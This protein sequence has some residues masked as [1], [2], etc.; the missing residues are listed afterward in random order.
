MRD[1]KRAVES[2][3][4]VARTVELGKSGT[5]TARTTAGV[6]NAYVKKGKV[7]GTVSETA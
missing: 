2:T 5:G 6:P 4:A 7:V 1:E 3:L